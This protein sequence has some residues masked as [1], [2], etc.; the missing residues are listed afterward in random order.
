MKT[1]IIEK[2]SNK[3]SKNENGRFERIIRSEQ[4]ETTE[5]LNRV[6]FFFF[7]CFRHN[8]T[9]QENVKNGVQLQ[10]ITFCCMHTHSLTSAWHK[11]KNIEHPQKCTFEIK[12]V[13]QR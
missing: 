6:F 13:K 4:E 2:K 5:L 10:M 11:A 1:K 7:A 12:N 8:I 9:T 3:A